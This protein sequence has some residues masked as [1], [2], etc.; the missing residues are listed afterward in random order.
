MAKSW[1]LQEAK[2]KFSEIVDLA[3]SKGPQLVSRRGKVEI[4]IISVDQYRKLTERKTSLLKFFQESPLKGED[5]DLTRSKD[6]GR[7]Q[8]DVDVPA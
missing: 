2:N 4:V 1:Q 3:L 8:G 5:L 6:T 7:E